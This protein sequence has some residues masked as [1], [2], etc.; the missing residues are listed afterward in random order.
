MVL[1]QIKIT[2]DPGEVDMFLEEFDMLIQDSD[3]SFD[4]IHIEERNGSVYFTMTPEDLTD[5]VSTII[6]L[7]AKYFDLETEMKTYSD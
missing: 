3:V 7:G 4:K 5:K 6:E 1:I 2:P